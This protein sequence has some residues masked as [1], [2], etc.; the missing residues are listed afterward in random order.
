MHF[1]TKLEGGVEIRRAVEADLIPLIELLAEMHEDDDSVPSAERAE[2][3]FRRIDSSDCRLILVAVVEGA[4]VG[5]LDLFVMPNLTRGARPW[6]GVENIVVAASHRQRGIARSLLNTAIELA[7]SAHCYKIQLVSH[8]RRD[9]AHHLYENVGFDAPV[10][11]Y[12]R[13]LH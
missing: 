1:S 9:A 7:R 3:T 4:L 11:G 10:R 8:A 2:S 5:T 13:Y 6:A 12:R